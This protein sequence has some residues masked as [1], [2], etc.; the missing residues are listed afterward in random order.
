[1]LILAGRLEASPTLPCY[2]ADNHAETFGWVT[3]TLDLDEALTL[4]LVDA[5]SDASA[6]ERSEEIREQLR[7]VASLEERARR[8]EAWRHSG[9]IQAYNWIEPLMPR[10]VAHVRWCPAPELSA[11]RLAE[12]TSETVGSLDGRSEVERRG[13]GSFASRW[14]TADLAAD[15]W[16]ISGPVLL[17]IDLDFFVGMDAEERTQSFERIWQLAMTWPG[18][19]GIA[20]SVS[21][22]WLTDDAEA[23]ALVAMAADA[24]LRTRGATLELDG[25][26]DRSPD[27]SRR[28]KEL[29]DSGRPVPR[30]TLEQASP[31]LRG[32]LGALGKRLRITGAGGDELPN[33][34]EI[35]PASGEPDTDGVWRF[36]LADCPDLSVAP[37]EGATGRVR[38]YALEPSHPAVDLWPETGLGKG[39]SERPARWVYETRRSL[40]LTDGRALPAD[41]WKP[42]S[43]GRVRI[44]AEVE[45]DRGW[46]P[47]G[48]VEIRV[49]TA[50]GFRGALSE[51]LGMPYVFGISRVT[52]DERTGVESGWGADCANLLVYAWRRQGIPLV[53]GDP[54]TLA[55]QLSTMGEDLSLADAPP[56][57]PEEIERGVAIDFGRHVVALWED[58][59]PL[60]R[61]SGNDLVIHHLGGF[62]EIVELSTLA[63]SRPRFALRNPIP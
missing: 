6:V 24:V 11:Q 7:R 34:I 22:P 45:T 60:G 35:R 29:S 43:G 51:C 1:M 28:N 48:A 32:T 47:A 31:A 9:R 16:D 20:F 27:G 21:R 62:P 5:H 53:W 26:L 15:D 44:A 13:A 40:G 63:E 30:W 55:R 58:R 59:P 12:L 8:V 10:P 57:S 23:D 56:V 4:V 39:F 41:R 36:P 2:L 38:W 3:R 14:D 18:L 46:L 17:A 54:S 49:S 42:A 19:R 61:L 37:C 33:P 52:D 25:R 50:E